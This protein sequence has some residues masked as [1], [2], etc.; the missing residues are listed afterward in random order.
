[1]EGNLVEAVLVVVVVGFDMVSVVF[2]VVVVDLVWK[3]KAV[4]AMFGH[5]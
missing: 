3:A 1:M 2:V 4:F 5:V